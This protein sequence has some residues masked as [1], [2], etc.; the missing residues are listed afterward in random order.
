[1]SRSQ[2]NRFE[3]LKAVL[4]NDQ[5]TPSAKT[6]ASALAVQFANDETGQINPSVRTLANYTTQ[7]T[8]TVKRAVKALVDAG[9]MGRSEGRG[10]GN[11]TAYVLCSPGKVVPITAQ[12]KGG[13]HAPSTE[14]KG[15]HMHLKGGTDA[16]SYNK[17]KQSFEQRVAV[18]QWYRSHRFTGNAYDGPAV[19]SS[20][21]HDALYAWA[22]WLKEQGLPAL[23]RFPI[24]APGKKNGSSFFLLPWKTPPIE[25]NM[26]AEAC[27]FFG[28]ML[29]LEDAHAVNS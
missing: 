1:M 16:P 13:T 23:D 24:E 11:K 4:Q 19:I 27:E 17:D 20:S 5:L 2:I 10:R 29:V 18:P 26:N 15:A 6:I 7:S 8:D 21:N 28:S 9:W 14:Q 22:S 3:W 12:N 25:A